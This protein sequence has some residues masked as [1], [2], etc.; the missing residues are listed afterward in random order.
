VGALAYTVG[1]DI[2]FAEGRY[3]PE[4]LDGRRLLAHELA[5]VVQQSEAVNTSTA[6]LAI[7]SADSALEREADQAAERVIRGDSVRLTIYSPRRQ[8]QR[9]N[10]T[11]FSCGVEVTDLIKGAMKDARAAFKGWD[12]DDK[13][14][15]C[16]ALV[17]L[18]T[19][20]IA[21]DI[22][23]MHGQVTGDLLNNRFRPACATSGATPACGS[24]VTVDGGC[25]FAGSANYVIFGVMCRL[26]SDFLADLW[27]RSAWYSYRVLIQG[28]KLRMLMDE[29]TESGMLGTIDLYKKWLPRLKFDSVASNIEAAKAW[30]KAG[31]NGW[32]SVPSPAPDRSNCA[33]DCPNKPDYSSFTVSWY[34]NLNPYARRRGVRPD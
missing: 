4:S 5:H 8:L 22:V 3:R 1:R 14:D 32:P 25:H 29:F 7:M 28:D 27:R 18:S 13:L 2:V 17:D 21:W 34:P 31:Y 30:S 23:E 24:S 9:A 16:Q 19:G 26:C 10:G 20:D 12:D 15:S 11:H 33:T 6:G